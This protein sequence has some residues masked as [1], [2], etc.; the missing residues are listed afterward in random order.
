MNQFKADL[1]TKNVYSK[2]NSLSAKV[3]RDLL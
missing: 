2:N 3:K 1:K